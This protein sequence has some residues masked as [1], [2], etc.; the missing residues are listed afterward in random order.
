MIF[1][2][3]VVSV[4][5]RDSSDIRLDVKPEGNGSTHAHVSHLFKAP[6]LS[7]APPSRLD[8]PQLSTLQLAVRGVK[9]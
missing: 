5:A 4:E 3:P 9:L 6:V 1:C 8:L 7:V 2:S